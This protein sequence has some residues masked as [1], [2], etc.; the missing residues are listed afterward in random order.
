MK[1]NLP[2]KNIPLPDYNQYKFDLCNLH[3]LSLPLN[4]IPFVS[5]GNLILLPAPLK[6]QKKGWPWDEESAVEFADKSLAP[7]LSIVIPSYQQGFFI[8]ETIRSILMQN[9]PNLE[10]IIIDGG[11]TDET[12][13]ILEYYKDFISTYI[14]EKDRGQAHA[15]NKGFS[16]ASGEIYYWIN[17]DDY[18][19]INSLNKV[20]SKFLQYPNLDIIY[21]DGYTFNEHTQQLRYDFASWVTERYL[22]F[23]GIVL[24]HSVLWKS[25]I[26]CSIWEEIHCA[27]DA[28]LW[29]RLFKNRKTK[30]FHFPI[31]TSRIHSC[32]KTSDMKA[33]SE[34]WKEDYQK[35]IW[36]FYPPINS[37]KWKWRTVEYR[38]VQR[39]Y[40]FLTRK[41]KLKEKFFKIKHFVPTTY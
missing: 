24:S 38:L 5:K 11:S 20:I 22:R 8:E 15:I 3:T 25:K 12:I 29:L 39:I 23:G 26:H 35:N 2:L 9:Y 34:K 16:L 30:H 27:M 13:S 28:E 1:E 10:L 37:V 40:Q 41:R 33:W 6:Q 18:L 21:G 7:K 14:S 36:K 4:I 19:N 31:G 32:Q 17:S